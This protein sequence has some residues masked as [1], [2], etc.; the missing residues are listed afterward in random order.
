[1]VASPSPD[2]RVSLFYWLGSS[3]IILVRFLSA[4][5]ASRRFV[6]GLGFVHSF[7]VLSFLLRRAFLFPIGSVELSVSSNPS[8]AFF[9]FSGFVGPGTHGPPHTCPFLCYADQFLS[10]PIEMLL[11]FSWALISI[12]AA[13]CRPWFAH[14][15]PVLF[16]QCVSLLGTAS[17]RF[18]P[19]LGWLGRAETSFPDPFL[20]LLSRCH[21]GQ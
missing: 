16:P 4:R 21:L 14:H 3:R 2:R 11:L 18:S 7:P 5:L 1:L 13:H 10:P 8:S 12:L 19:S 9:P 6:I 20:R 17:P 15:P